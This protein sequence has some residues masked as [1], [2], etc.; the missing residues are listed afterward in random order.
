MRAATAREGALEYGLAWA[1]R[2]GP[3]GP[4]ENAMI[5]HFVFNFLDR[6]GGVGNRLSTFTQVHLVSRIVDLLH[7]HQL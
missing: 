6:I 7:H 4:A 2:D 1:G 3:D 5:A